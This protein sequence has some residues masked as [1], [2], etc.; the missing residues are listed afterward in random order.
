MHLQTTKYPVPGHSFWSADSSADGDDDDFSSRPPKIDIRN[1]PHASPAAVAYIQATWTD[2][3]PPELM[4]ASREEEAYLRAS[5]GQYDGFSTRVTGFVPA[6]NIPP[7]PGLPRYLDKLILNS[8]VGEQ[9]APAVPG[10]NGSV[11]G[12]SSPR[13]GGR[14]DGDGQSGLVGGV[15]SGQGGGKRERRD[16]ED[17]REREERRERE[18]EERKERERSERERERNERAMR[19][20]RGNL[21]PAPPPSETGEDDDD[22]GRPGPYMAAQLLKQYYGA[23]NSAAA[24]VQ[25][26]LGGS[27]SLPT[28]TSIGPAG[29]PSTSSSGNTIV[30]QRGV[31]GGVVGG[32]SGTSKMES[33]ATTPQQNSGGPATPTGPMSPNQTPPTIA[34]H[35]GYVGTRTTGGMISPPPA[36]PMPPTPQHT[37]RAPISGSRAITIDDANMPPL[38]DDNSVLPVPS[39]VVLHHLCTSAIR[40]G[41]LAVA[42]TTRYR[43]KV[44]FSLEASFS[45]QKFFAFHF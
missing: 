17:R 24:N 20:R 35:W 3:F 23:S 12:G 28:G 33:G 16:R 42:N 22:F 31:V 44:G 37:G 1:H 15:G 32:V 45:S 5:A 19:A 36:Q 7:A 25:A 30:G 41:V 43:K 40:N 21:P 18:R 13:R 39:H 4:E 6:P 9:K 26:N 29:N 14:G 38:T 27:S 2:V 8:K 34:P 10:S 11:A